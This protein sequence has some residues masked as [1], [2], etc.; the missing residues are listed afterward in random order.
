MNPQYDLAAAQAHFRAR[1]AY[2]TGVHELEGMIQANRDAIIVVDLRLQSDYARGHVPGAVN[3]PKGKWH[4]AKGL[5][6]GATHYLYCYDQTCHLAAEA[7]I[8]LTAQGFHVV[9]V[10]GGWAGWEAKGF[11]AEP[12]LAAA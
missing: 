9:E 6:R 10:E 5:R 12:E 3:L 4:T 2:T 8:E 7:A 1:I 11:R